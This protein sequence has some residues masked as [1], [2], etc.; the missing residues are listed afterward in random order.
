[1]A[2]AI[3]EE[4]DPT[5]PT[6][7][8]RS[9]D[10]SRIDDSEKANEH[11]D[12]SCSSRQNPPVIDESLYSRQL[13]VLG[14][15]AMVRMA[16]SDVLVSGLGGLGVEVAKNI[17]LAGVGSVTLHDEMACTR[18]DLSSQYYLNKDTLG[19]NRAEACEAPLARLNKYVRVTTHTKPLTEEFLKRFDVVVLTETPLD[20]Q[21]YIS[22]VTRDRNIALI[23]ADTR[24]LAGQIFCDFGDNFH[25]TDANGEQPISVLIGSITKANEGV[26]TCLDEMR[27]GFEDNDYVTFSEVEGMT[28]INNCPPMK[29]KVLSPSTFSVGD[30]TQFG[31]YTLGGVA[32]QVKVPTDVK[33]KS[34]KESLVNP[35]FVVSDFAKMN[36]PAHLHLGF[37]ALHAFE[38]LHSRLPRPWNKE[39]AAVVVQLAM[40][41]NKALASP[42]DKVDQEL[43]MVL[44]CVSAGSLCPV[45]AVIGSVA[46]QEVIKACSGKFRPIQQ[47]FYFDAFE[48]LPQES[49]VTEPDANAMEHSRY[50]GQARVFGANVQRLLMTQ[51]YFVVGA[52]AVGGELLKN[53]AMM[54]IGVDNGCIHVT[55]MDVIERSNLNRHFLL[56][57][58]DVGAMK[59]IMAAQS[60]VEMN[61]EINI[62]VRVDRVGPNTEHIYNDDFFESLDGVV[63]AVD[64]VDTRRYVDGR[65]VLYG[66]PLLESGTRG[67]RGSVQVVVPHMT[68]SYSSSPD[69]PEKPTPIYTIRHFPNNIEHILQWAREEFEGLF[70]QSAANAVQYLTDPDFLP[71]TL[72]TLQ[73]TQKVA[74]LKEIK[75]IL[76]DE[77]A[78]YFEDCVAFA[79]LR[80]QEQYSDQIRQLLRV[81]PENHVTASGAPFW[82][83]HRHCPRPIEFDSRE[84]LHMDY[85]VAAAN[86]RATMFGIPHC[87]DREEIADMLEEVDVPARDT[88]QEDV[89]VAANEA[90]PPQPDVPQ[91]DDE[92][93]LA[94]LLEQLPDPDDLDYVSLKTLEFETDDDTNFHVDF[95]VAASNL[96]AANYGIEPADR[97]KSKLIAGK[98]IPAVA[99]TASLVAGLASLELYKLAQR[100]DDLKLFKN[101]FVNLALPFFCFAEPI[102]PRKKKF[103]DQE[104]TLWDCLEVEGKITLSQF[105]EHIE[106]EHNVKIIAVSEG[107][108]VLYATFQPSSKSRLELSMSEVVEEVS[109]QKIDPDKRALI[110]ELTC[111]NMNGQDVELPRVRYMLPR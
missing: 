102:A 58:H 29:V 69:P 8:H 26:V 54:G 53:F 45:Q 64:N 51:R 47:W 18:D 32:T 50:A 6:K 80:F 57:S 46:A 91:T 20:E 11:G 73:F 14:R 84:T 98:I 25:V 78:I 44:S 27:H 110:F 76:V 95:I 109:K 111:K 36:R 31:D 39:D 63:T 56:R 41:K 52:G 88:Q 40:E 17:V 60:L 89:Q 37:Q 65:C 99:T 49:D 94:K 30:T 70:K 97:L 74:L 3:D 82:S 61:P 9:D 59:S 24:G 62:H 79:R 101:G 1:M 12:K 34:F 5:P 35:D 55:D 105:L 7:R 4:E 66:K 75:K 22:D 38:E 100:H 21:E 28:E 10:H 77:Q 92:E 96:R 13:Y 108:R 103:N 16:Q 87:T 104:F 68:E 43:I 67:T 48:C 19:Q 83:R 106:N 107:E 81:Y 86:L 33:F 93:L 2:A 90:N 71:K 23:V 42:L 15:D 85:I 72:E